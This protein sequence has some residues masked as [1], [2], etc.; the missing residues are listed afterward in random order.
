M[1]GI[2]SIDPLAEPDFV[3]PCAGNGFLGAR[4][5]KLLCSPGCYLPVVGT[6]LY[7]DGVQLELASPLMPEI[8]VDGI[9]YRPESGTHKA[10]LE[11]LTAS[12]E[13]RL[14][15]RWEYAAGK[16]ARLKFALLIPRP[17]RRFLLLDCMVEAECEIRLIQTLVPPPASRFE[18]RK[19]AWTDNAM[20]FHCRT[21]REHSDF[22]QE[23]RW[24]NETA[25][26]RK[27]G[28][29]I[30]FTSTGTLALSFQMAVN[31]EFPA[32]PVAELRWNNRREWMKLWS[33]ALTVP[34]LSEERCDQLELFQYQL[35]AN[36][37]TAGVVCGPLGV[38]AVG[39]NGNQFWDSDFYLFRPLLKLWPEFARSILQY[40]LNTLPMAR[41]EA[42][43]RKLAG[44]F[45]GF[46]C[47]N[48]GIDRTPGPWRD[49]L[50]V[51]C[52]IA[53]SAMEF[54]D[55][56]GDRSFLV[57]RDEIADML[58]SRGEFDADGSFHLRNLIG[59][60]ELVAERDHAICSDNY[61]TNYATALILEYSGKAEHLRAARA[62][63]YPPA[64]PET[65][66]RPAFCGYRGA[67][68]KQ[69]DFILCIYPLGME[70]DKQTARANVEYYNRRIHSGGPMMTAGIE[71]AIL[72]L[73]GKREEALER[74]FHD[75]EP[76]VHGAF[77]IVSETRGNGKS[78]FLTGIGA[79]LHGLLA[80]CRPGFTQRVYR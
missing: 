27:L 9:P 6:E 21:L 47:D 67:E 26:E 19:T 37:N 25:A 4:V 23:L 54:A 79:F 42:R 52:W 74:L 65:G 72:A 28:R 60:D 70:L 11:L 62:M 44:A 14:T 69:A 29:K 76:F 57:L 35:L 43:A 59:P 38:S 61:L 18:V 24:K 75:S 46:K 20:I 36:L 1:K 2:F 33:A 12:G 56:T 31:R 16:Y 39:W 34:E 30:S 8:M 48:K 73:L 77:R 10:S 13:I 66:I 5:G 32:L 51:N 41:Q 53:L 49:E 71:C 64:D 3:P 15:D 58:Y 45:Y 68:I 17:C 40:R 78:C 63:Y 22:T 80:I 7:D 55:N 50:H